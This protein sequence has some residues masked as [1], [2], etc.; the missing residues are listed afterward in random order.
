M[1]SACRQDYRKCYRSAQLSEGGHCIESD[2][3]CMQNAKVYQVFVTQMHNLLEGKIL[4]EHVK[5]TKPLNVL[6]YSLS[7]V[8]VT[9]VT[10]QH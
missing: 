7:S 4:N 9:I 10:D 5:V 8:S 3:N 6:W 1:D 2:V